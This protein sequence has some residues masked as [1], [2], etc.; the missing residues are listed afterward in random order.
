MTFQR[1]P[2]CLSMDASSCAGRLCRS[3][4]FCAS[5]SSCS[6]EPWLVRNKNRM[7]FCLSIFA[8]RLSRLAAMLV[9]VA[10]GCCATV[11]RLLTSIRE[12]PTVP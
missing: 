5:A 11:L 8:P 12:R 7:S 1:M 3:M 4:P 9:R 10:I 2:L 6:G